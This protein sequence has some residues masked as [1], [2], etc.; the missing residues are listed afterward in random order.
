[1]EL[2]AWITLAVLAVMIVVL[3]TER[4]PPGP[5]VL[6]A[7]VLLMLVGVTTPEQ[8]FAGFSNEAPIIVACLLIVARAVDVAG[9][10]QPI[11][12]RLFRGADSSTG[13]LSRLL[14]PLAGISAF[15]NNTTLVAMT[16]PA[17][18][19]ISA[20]R[21]LPASRFL[22]PVSYAAIL[23][24]VATAIGTSTNLTVSGLLVE[25]G[26][27]P[28]GLFEPTL[29]GL[30]IALA[31][32]VALILLAPRL[33]PDRT[34][35]GGSLAEGGRDF[36][37][38][39]QVAPGGEADGT[40]VSEAGLRQLQG[41]FLVEIQRDGRSIAPVAPDERLQ[42]GDLLTFVG[43]VDNIVDLQRVRGL[44]STEARQ[45]GSLAG[46]VHAF[47]ELVV[48]DG[49]DLVGQTLKQ[50]D[51]RAR[52]DAA[53]IAIHRAGQRV[54]AKL[55]DVPLRVG[56]TLLVLSDPGFRGRWRDRPDFLV[57]A[58]LSGISPRQPRR[59]WLIGAVFLGFVLATGSGLVPILQASIAAA[60]VVIATGVLTLRQARDAVD[61]QIII[62]IAAAFGLGAA[63]SSSGLADT[64]A[65][66]LVN[67]MSPFG[68]L[69]ALAA[70]LIAT[71][72][73]T[74]LLSNN[75]AAALMFPIGVAT[76][77]VL[78]ADPRPFVI[79]IMLA[80]SLSFLTPIGYQTN[81]MVYGLGGYKFSDYARVGVPLNVVTIILS[82]TLVPIV[83]PFNP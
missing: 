7:T 77:A 14:F 50:V 40:S 42:G 30:P 61:L 5:A 31:G 3:Y 9:I 69:G 63:V 12:T 1:M 62:M 34:P 6:G 79:V 24:G 59:A 18:I 16:V 70:I 25:A 36:T 78:G 43:R 28:M 23:G 53:V 73:L 49:G 67:V 83:F 37:V 58:P 27:E 65:S 32:V 21:N 57:I 76:A 19:D 41:V 13:I 82:L 74:E 81:L 66:G 26:M 55:G 56:D 33:L 2:S 48:G 71:M 46:N 47:Y 72:A 15:I 52:Y 17:V 80:A 45:I 10:M 29:V 22:M 51:F 11:V 75:A 35:V 44:A 64:I 38:T 60:L 8:A 68:N 39:M 54:D 4:V 20:R